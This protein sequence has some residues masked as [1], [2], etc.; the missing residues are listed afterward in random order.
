MILF[1]T[2]SNHQPAVSLLETPSSGSSELADAFVLQ[3][4]LAQATG[5]GPLAGPHI[6]RVLLVDLRQSREALLQVV[7]HACRLVGIKN[8]NN[9]PLRVL[10]RS[11]GAVWHPL[12]GRLDAVRRQ[13]A[14]DLVVIAA[15]EQVPGTGFDWLGR[16]AWGASGPWGPGRDQGPL[17]WQRTWAAEWGLAFV[18]HFTTR[19]GT[20]YAADPE[21]FKRG[22]DLAVI[23]RPERR[24]EPYGRQVLTD[25]TGGR[26]LV[27]RTRSG[28]WVPAEVSERAR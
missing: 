8:S 3:W 4:A 27:R 7:Q 23:V 6:R 28:L 1:T 19:P 5:A 9:A 11:E 25:A 10:G 22:A 14:P 21:A 2:S 12:W 18:D 26:L 13:F 20:P 15:A 16:D 17:G 24:G